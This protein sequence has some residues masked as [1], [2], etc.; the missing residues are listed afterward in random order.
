MTM[1]VTLSFI[2][3][4]LFSS[5]GDPAFAFFTGEMTRILSSAAMGTG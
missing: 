5:F 4:M 1:K 2:A 3:L